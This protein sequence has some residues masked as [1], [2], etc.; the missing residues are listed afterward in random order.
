MTG[1]LLETKA[2][3]A[4]AKYLEERGWSVAVISADRI[5]GPVI[6]TVSDLFQVDN[7]EIIFRF[8]GSPPLESETSV[9]HGI[10]ED[11]PPSEPKPESGPVV[12]QIDS[13]GGTK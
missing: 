11:A 4:I 9:S 8:T 12:S 1:T 10:L 3:F 2:L 6:R 13:S 7:Y 5:Q